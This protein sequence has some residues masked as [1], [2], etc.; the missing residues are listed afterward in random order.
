VTDRTAVTGLIAEVMYDDGAVIYLNGTE[1]KRLSMPTGTITAAT[2]AF[3]HE[4]NNAYARL[5]LSAFRDRLGPGEHLLAVEVHQAEG[6][7]S[8]LV[9]DLALE[10]RR[11]PVFQ[12]FAGNPLVTTG[13]PENDEYWRSGSVSTP[14]VVRLSASA[15]VMYF[16]GNDDAG[17]HYQI[18]RATSTDGIQWQV[19]PAPVLSGAEHVE[20]VLHDGAMYR[21]YSNPFWDNGINVYTS[22]D[23]V[24]WTFRARAASSGSAASVIQDGTTFKMWL[25]E[26]DG[27]HY[28]T[29][30][31]GLTWT[32]H[33]IV[34]VPAMANNDI[35]VMKDGS[36]YKMWIGE[37]AGMRYL[38][39]PDG[40]AWTTR[41]V[42]LARGA[43]G[44]WDADRVYHPFVMRDGSVLKMWYVGTGGTS[45]PAIGYATSP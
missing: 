44:T 14:T 4:A 18:G 29:S 6:S 10:Y 33:G 1:I 40:L 35:T 7:S 39:S 34:L 43:A 42:S 8:D 15:W 36:A 32:R 9:F 11:A 28:A 22:T 41:G 2:R 17:P 26:S 38:T 21:L 3:G 25:S 23:G 5:D 20:A 24:T 12:R 19:D 37:E 13:D 16:T 30:A 45:E 27:L 31:D